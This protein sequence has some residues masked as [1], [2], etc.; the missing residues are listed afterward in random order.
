M[1]CWYLLYL[2]LTY[3]FFYDGIGWRV[4]DVWFAPL[5]W[6]GEIEV[7]YHIEKKKYIK[8]QL[9][10][11]NNHVLN[12]EYLKYVV[13]VMDGNLPMGVGVFAGDWFLTAGHVIVDSTWIKWN[14]KK[15][16]LRRDDAE[17]FSI[18]GD[19]KRTDV[20]DLAVFRIDG[21][22]SPLRLASAPIK[23]GMKLLYLSHRF[24]SEKHGLL[25]YREQFVPVIMAGKVTSIDGQYFGCLM[26]ELLHVG[27]SGSPVL[28]GDVVYGLVYAGGGRDG[29]RDVHFQSVWELP[30]MLAI[31]SC[32]C[33]HT[34]KELTVLSESATA[35]PFGLPF[36]CTLQPFMVDI[37]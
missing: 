26:E 28:I 31:A 33:K 8:E 30:R 16:M 36:S 9:K 13:P 32:T 20:A 24:V 1:I 25:D 11:K 35:S 4:V 21:I 15:I 3:L 18:Q 37:L 10:K 14:N 5:L 12:E 22:G 6:V 7:V 19:E 27:D 34:G 23:E 29:S 2:P 17:F